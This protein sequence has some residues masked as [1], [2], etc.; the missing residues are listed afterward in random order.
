PSLGLLPER[1]CYL[2]YGRLAGRRQ[3]A[4]ARIARATAPK[5]AAR[6]RSLHP[7]HGSASLIA[8]L[9]FSGVMPAKAAS[10]QRHVACPSR[11]GQPG[12]A[13]G[14]SAALRAPAAWIACQ[15]KAGVAG[16]SRFVTPSGDSASRRA[17]ITAGGAPMAPASPEPLMPSG[18][19]LQ[20]ISIERKA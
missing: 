5:R 2:D 10:R 15:T 18:L 3:P 13:A 20:G 12:G 7:S 11:G 1:V 14:Y 8:W 16:M 6:Q 9:S 19:V 17:F 4:F